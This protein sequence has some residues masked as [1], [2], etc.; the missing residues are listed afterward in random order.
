MTSP[1]CPVTVRRP[2]PLLLVASTNKSWPPI[3]VTPRPI[4]TPTV[5]RSARSGSKIS[6]PMMCGRWC[7]STVMKPSPSGPQPRSAAS[8]A[9]SFSLLPSDE[10][11]ESWPPASRS[12]AQ[13]QICAMRRSRERTPLSIVH[14][15]TR[16][17]MAV[18]RTFSSG[19]CACSALAGS[20]SGCSGC[21][22]C[23]SS[24][25]AVEDEDGV[26]DCGSGS[27]PSSAC[28]FRCFGRR[29]VMAMCA[30]SSTVYPE[31]SITSMRSSR[32][33]SMACKSLQVQRKSTFDRSNGVLM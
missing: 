14:L 10:A 18:S 26:G 27:L 25:A 22:A 12:A 2:E 4:A 16:S 32:G 24:A 7:D 21:S 23:S 20:A 28:S 31:R 13:R 1:S 19:S 17:V 30:F 5:K 6:A 9:S 33:R 15:D 11:A 29:C 3:C 8:A